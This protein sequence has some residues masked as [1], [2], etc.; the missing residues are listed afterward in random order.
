VTREDVIA[1]VAKDMHDRFGFSSWH[2]RA[3]RNTWLFR[4]EA[5]LLA[6]EGAGLAGPW[7]REFTTQS[8]AF[9]AAPEK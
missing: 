9:A 1:T 6:L 5:A 3:T 8:S 4:A 7:P 2:Q